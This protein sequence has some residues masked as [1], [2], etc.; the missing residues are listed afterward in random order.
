MTAFY[1]TLNGGLGRVRT[2][3]ADLRPLP[4]LMAL[5]AVGAAI[6]GAFFGI[7]FV[8]L[9]PPLPAVSVVDPAPPLVEPA[10]SAPALEARHD[11]TPQIP[12]PVA[13]GDNAAANPFPDILPLSNPAVNGAPRNRKAPVLTTTLASPAAMTHVR[14][15]RLERRHHQPIEKYSAGLWRPD[16]RAGPLPGGGFYGPPNVNT[17]YINPR[18]GR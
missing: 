13:T 17:G 14:R 9:A 18:G 4:Y 7:S 8:W 3:D 16:A 2:M 12:S 10:A 5:G 1:L 11:N 6:V 15:L